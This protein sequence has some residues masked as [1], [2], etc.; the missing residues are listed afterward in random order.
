[1]TAAAKTR[2]RRDIKP[3]NAN[4]PRVI[5]V[6]APKPGTRDRLVDL[7]VDL[8]DEQRRSGGR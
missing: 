1:M 7:L 4:E 5:V 2:A 6:R 3:A 8:L